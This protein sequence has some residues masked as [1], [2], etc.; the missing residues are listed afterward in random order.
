MTRSWR[1][2]RILCRAA[3]ISGGK[4]RCGIPLAPAVSA[5]RGGKGLRCDCKVPDEAG[6]RIRRCDPRMGY[7]NGAAGRDCK[8]MILPE[9]P[10]LQPTGRSFSGRFRLRPGRAASPGGGPGSVP[11]ERRDGV[12]RGPGNYREA[13]ASTRARISR[14]RRARDSARLRLSARSFA[15]C[16]SWSDLSSGS[17]ASM[18]SR[19]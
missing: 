13:T 1:T 5:A 7:R 3:C 2:A 19:S 6:R 14:M 12:V 4:R 9:G 11:E 18:A 16:L 10:P 15:A 17:W 8:K